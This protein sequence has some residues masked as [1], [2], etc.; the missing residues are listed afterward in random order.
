MLPTGAGP[1]IHG[2]I[3]AIKRFFGRTA[4]HLVGCGVNLDKR[5]AGVRGAAISNPHRLVQESLNL[6]DGYLWAILS[7]DLD[8]QGQ[9]RR[10]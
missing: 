4:I 2:R 8:R 9:T 1:D 5:A 3:Y 7:N 10:I 6:A